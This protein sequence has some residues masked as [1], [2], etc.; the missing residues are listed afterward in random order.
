MAELTAEQ[1]RERAMAE[2]AMGRSTAF[3]QMGS[4]FDVGANRYTSKDQF[5]S[6]LQATDPVTKNELLQEINRNLNRNPGPVGFDGTQFDYMQTLLRRGGFSKAKTPIGGG[7]LGPGDAE[8]LSTVIG[9]AYAS[10]KDPLTFLSEYNQSVAA[11]GPKQQDTT[12]KYTKQIQTALQFKDLGDARQYYSDAYFVAFGKYPPAELDTKFQNSW[13]AN[14]V[15]QNRP[16]T[17]EGKT[18]FEPVYD[19]KSKPVMDK[20]TGQQKKDKFGNLVFSK[21]SVNEKGQLQ[22]KTKSTGTS[23]AEGQGFTEEEQKQFLTTFLAENYPGTDFSE[24][25][26]GGAAKSIYDAIV[27]LHKANYTTPPAFASVSGLITKII[28]TPDEKVQTE[29][30]NQYSSD[31]QNNAVTRFN[32]LSSLV[33]PGENASKYISPVLSSLSTAL[34]REV[35][36]DSDIAKEIFNFKGED[37]KYRM[38]NDFELNKF[39]KS[40]PEYGKTSTAINESINLAQSLKNALG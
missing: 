22:Y 17:T 3:A 37:G 13:N 24:G 1:R 9:L 28:G 16:T 29:L 31:I 33:K 39:I 7:I 25:D 11:K 8:G 32:S 30:F 4:G 5:L 14:V 26:V 23:T 36:I 19:I 2:R 21:I 12:T 18:E 38:P 20:T 6:Y 27:E 34:E 10:N 40:R 15:S 35:T